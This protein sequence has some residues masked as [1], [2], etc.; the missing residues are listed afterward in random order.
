MQHRRHLPVVLAGLGAVAI[1]VGIHQG[2]V[3]VAPGY[4][5]RVVSGWGGPLNHEERHLAGVA[6]LGVAGAAISLR[7]RWLAAV[8]ALSGGVVLFYALRATLHYVRDPGLYT[9]VETYGGE[10]VRYIIGAEP[11]LLVV[12]AL[13]LAAAGVSGGRPDRGRGGA[14]TPRGST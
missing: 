3:H 13:L 8:P 5:G 2:L 1:V 4:E 10:T 11:A 14:E 12:G 9:P 7:S 6:I